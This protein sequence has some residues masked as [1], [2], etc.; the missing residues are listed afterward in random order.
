MKRLSRVVY[1]T[2]A[3]TFLIT[4]KQ[5]RRTE[6]AASTRVS[7]SIQAHRGYFCTRLARMLHIFSL[8]H[9]T[10]NATNTQT[11]EAVDFFVFRQRAMSKPPSLCRSTGSASLKLK[12]PERGRRWWAAGMTGM[13]KSSLQ[14]T[15]QLHVTHTNNIESHHQSRHKV[16]T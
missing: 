2:I 16:Q 13:F 12:L 14:L 7:P 3:R 4:H 6:D 10:L 5:R 1:R 11:N 15:F 9:T 8:M